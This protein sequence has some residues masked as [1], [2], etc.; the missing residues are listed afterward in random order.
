[1]APGMSGRLEEKTAIVVGAGPRPGETLGNGRAIAL[2]FAEEGAAVFCVDRDLERAQETVALVAAQS[3][4]A[5]AHCADATKSEA[6]AGLVEAALATLGRID[7]LVNNVGIGGGG[8]GPLHRADEEAW[9]RIM[10][11]NLKSFFLATKHVLAP[12]RVQGAGAIVNIA[13][14]AAIAG[15]HQIAYEVSKAGVNRLT[16]HVALSNAKH[17]VRCNAI[18]L[19]LIDTPM[20]VGGIARASGRPIEDVRAERHAR[21]PLKGGMGTARDTAN[22]ALFLASDEARFITGAVL[23]VDGGMS[24]RIG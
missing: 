23:P 20:A 7:I 3:G 9:D 22:A 5:F 12:M 10:A 13:S 19:G 2:R 16:L 15:A 4:R 18:L 1:M 11:V 17:G 14:L 21:V 24:T 6:C 8:D